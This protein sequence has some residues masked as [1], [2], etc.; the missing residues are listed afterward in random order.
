ME[1]LSRNM[2]KNVKNYT[3]NKKGK[4]P[5]RWTILLVDAHGK[6]RTI[7][8]AKGLLTFLI[9]LLIVAIGTAA[10]FS[11]L[12]FEIKKDKG[13]LKSDLEKSKQAIH[14]L[15]REKELLST[16]LVVAGVPIEEISPLASTTHSG[17]VEEEDN[18]EPANGNP[19]EDETSKEEEGEETVESPLETADLPEPPEQQ[20][21]ES[22]EVDEKPPEIQP[23]R[24]ARIELE[25]FDADFSDRRRALSVKFD[26]KNIHPKSNRVTGR[27]FL[28]LKEDETV[29]DQ[30]TIVPEVRLESGIP[31]DKTKGQ[32]FSIARFKNVEFY[33]RN[34]KDADQ[35]NW[36]TVLVFSDNG[37]LLERK[38][39]PIQIN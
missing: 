30:W 18:D 22:V 29:M 3:K 23:I 20:T 6:T 35:L 32:Y 27:I 1:D 25:N 19:V 9:F 37:D 2:G 39:Y 4:K 15:R 36:A 33:I 8:W 5:V 26:I 17:A 16:R 10:A 28:I 31:V 21:E 13:V 12:Y 34:V 38:T 14:A 11:Y 24:P 7:R